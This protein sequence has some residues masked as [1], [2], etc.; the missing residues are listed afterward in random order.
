MIKLVKAAQNYLSYDSKS[1][2]HRSLAIKV[3][4]IIVIPYTYSI[5]QV[6]SGGVEWSASQMSV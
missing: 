2:N 4:L 6:S 3:T 5:D 1:A